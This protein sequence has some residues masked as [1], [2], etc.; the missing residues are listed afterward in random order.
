VKSLLFIILPI[1]VVMSTIVSRCSKNFETD[2]VLQQLVDP[3]TR[4]VNALQ[5]HDDELVVVYTAFCL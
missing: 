2:T 1:F 3:E 4:L 5:D